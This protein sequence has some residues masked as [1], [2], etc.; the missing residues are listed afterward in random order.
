[1]FLL[2]K[3][4]LFPPL[5]K[6]EKLRCS[7]IEILIFRKFALKFLNGSRVTSPNLF[8][9]YCF[10]D[11]CDLPK[12]VDAWN[13]LSSK[14]KWD[15]HLKGWIDEIA[16][17]YLASLED[18]FVVTENY[19]D[20]F[21]RSSLQFNML[22]EICYPPWKRNGTSPTEFEEASERRQEMGWFYCLVDFMPF[23]EW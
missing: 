4:S 2:K 15:D 14:E 11:H 5:P 18:N 1:M 19:P 10:N 22:Q 3:P 6:K 16:T 7:H 17:E 12:C 21:L 8:S 23:R 20:F 13:N 9:L